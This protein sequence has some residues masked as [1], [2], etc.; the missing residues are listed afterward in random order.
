MADDLWVVQ[1]ICCGRDMGIVEFP[2]G[3]TWEQADAF[4]R[5]YADMLRAAGFTDAADY[6]D[7]DK[8]KAAGTEPS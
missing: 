5:E 3:T 2:P 1:T 8:P 4:R 6:V 7:P